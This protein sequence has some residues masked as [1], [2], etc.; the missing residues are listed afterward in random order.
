[1][2]EILTSKIFGSQGNTQDKNMVN[3]PESYAQLRMRL[4]RI[5]ISHYSLFQTNLF[6]LSPTRNSYLEKRESLATTRKETEQ[7]SGGGN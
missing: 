5:N 3:L 4:R 2:K 7:L 6:I 1:M